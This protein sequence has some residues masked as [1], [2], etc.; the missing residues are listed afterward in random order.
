M[1]PAMARLPMNPENK[2]KQL[3]CV[4][5]H[6]AH[7]FDTQQAAKVSCQQCHVD[8]HSR[9]FDGSPH[10]ALW[11]LELDGSKPQG[12]GVSCSTCH[13]PRI[14]HEDDQGNERILVD[15]NQN[16]TLRPNDKMLRPV[17]LTCHG[18]GFAMDA[19]A[20]PQLIKNNFTG[21]PSVHVESIDMA[22]EV[23]RIFREKKAARMKK[24]KPA[25]PKE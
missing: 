14:W 15:H 21:Q 8:D 17:C 10:A 18:L 22:R 4:S 19:L 23:D 5:C 9:N 24:N 16:N 20:D 7:K 3:T 6:G 2:H 11:K 13:M 12:T 25:T 1:T